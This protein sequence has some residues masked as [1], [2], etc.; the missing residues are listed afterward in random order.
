VTCKWWDSWW[1]NEGFGALFEYL[2]IEKV[3]PDIGVRH[4]FNLQKLQNGLKI[5]G[6]ELIHPMYFEPF[7]IKNY[8]YAMFYD[9]GEKIMFIDIFLILIL[10]FFSF[11][12]DSNVPKR[13]RRRKL[14]KS[15][16]LLFD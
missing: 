16:E 5:E 14:Q 9:K 11:K 6:V 2:L 10:I 3:Y 13:C 15:F 7:D 12:R 8:N 1:L 4:F